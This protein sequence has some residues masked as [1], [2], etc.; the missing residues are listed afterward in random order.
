M[1]EY[2]RR[3]ACMNVIADEINSIKK[4]PCNSICINIIIANANAIIIIKRK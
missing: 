2:M 4:T 1:L 3:Y